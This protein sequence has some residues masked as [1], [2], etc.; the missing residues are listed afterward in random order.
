MGVSIVGIIINIVMI[1]IIIVLIAIGIRFNDQLKTCETKQSNFCYS[2]QCPC[3]DELGQKQP[4]C[5]GYAKLPAD[6]SGQWYCSNAPLSI[7]NDQG[8][9]V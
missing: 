6:K 5:F 2:I 4:P 3:D 1:I 7:V 9:L 8:V